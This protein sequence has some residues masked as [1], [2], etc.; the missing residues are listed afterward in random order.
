MQEKIHST[1]QRINAVADDYEKRWAEYLANTHEKVLSVVDAD[2]GDTILDVSAGTGLLA[3]R[4]ID[5]GFPY[6]KIVLNDPSHKMLEKARR[7]FKGNPRITFTEHWADAIDLEPQSFNKIFCTSAFHNYPNQAG[8][9]N[10][11]ETL[12]EPDGQLIILDWDNSGWF[13]PI[14][15]YIKL[16]VREEIINT[17]SLKETVH[18]LQNAGFEII[19]RK[20]WYFN[21]WKLFLIKAKKAS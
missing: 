18:L 15:W 10:H 1:V 11:L 21:Y 8:T 19:C 17:R 14:N 13:R 4:Y 12:L 6:K 5:T 7:R 9:I 3:K 20:K 16:K 2:P